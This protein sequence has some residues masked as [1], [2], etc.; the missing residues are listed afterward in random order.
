MLKKRQ[1][2]FFNLTFSQSFLFLG[3][4]SFFSFCSL[5]AQNQLFV[6]S[7]N[8]GMIGSYEVAVDGSITA[9]QFASEGTDA[10]GI[11]YDTANDVLYQLNRTDSRIDVYSNVSTNP[12]LVT[13]STSDFT[14]GREI[15]V[16]GNK[17]VVADDVAGAGNFVVY[18]ITPTSIS[19]DKIHN[20]SI[21]LWGIHTNGNQLIAIVDASS[22]VA[23]FENFF[24]QAGGA[25][26]ASATVT[27]DGLVRT[28]GLTY[29]AENDDMYLTDI[30]AASSAT[31]GA[32]IRV[33]NW[34]S[35]IIDGSVNPMEQIRVEGGASLLG[36]PVDIALDKAN[37]MVY[38]AERARDGGR[39]L[40]FKTPSATG[41]VAPTY[42]ELF[43]G[44]S[45]VFLSGVETSL[46]TCDFVSGGSVSFVNG[47][48]ETTIIVD[49]ED[50][51]LSFASTV[52]A[53]ASNYSFT[54]V[55][56]DGSAAG[57]I[58]GI[59]PS[60]T[61]EFNGAGLGLCKVYGLSYTGNLTITGGD[62]L[63]GGQDLSDDCFM[64]SSN[65][66]KVNRVAPQATANQFF[67]SSNT[68]G[69]I[70]AYE[71]LEDGSVLGN[72]FSSVDLDAD[73]IHYDAVNDVLYQLN[74]T[75][76]RVD[77][78]SNGSTNPTLIASS[79]SDFTNGREIAVTGSK[80]VVADD[81]AGGGNLVVYNITPTSITLDRIY[82]T[83]IEL[84]GIH[85]NGNQLIAVVDASDNV[86][87]Y[88]DFFNQQVGSISASATIAI[89]GLVRTHGLTYDSEN[90]DM[91][92]T[93]I[94]LASSAT[95]GALVRV[96][97]WTAASADG[98]VTASEQIRVKGIT[99]LLGN[100]V[101]IALD[102]DND[103][104]YVAERARDGGRILGFRAPT[105]TGGI[106]PTYKRLF[107]GASAVF[108]SGVEAELDEC[109]YVESGV[110]SFSTGG[111]EQTIVIDG[112]SDVLSFQS[113]VGPE[114]QGINF[115]YVVTNE[116]GMILGI[117]PSNLV[118]FD[119]AGLGAC[120]VY[121]LT[122]TGVLLI[123]AGDD[124][125]GG[126]DLSSDC[127]KLS[128]NNLTVIRTAS[129]VNAQLFASS[130]TTGKIGVFSFLDDGNALQDEFDSQDVDADGIYFD[131]ENDV[132]YQLNR[133]ASVVNVYSDVNASLQAGN[134][135]TLVATS[136]SDFTN[137]REIAVSGGKLIVADDVT[138]GGNLVIYD[139]T[140]TSIA[141]DKVLNTSIELWGIHANG[142]QLIAVVDASGD[143]AIFEDV[144]N[145]PAGA[146]DADATISIENLVRTHG[147]TYDAEEDY[148][149]LTD[150]GSASFAGDGALITIAN[151]TA[152]I[153]DGT[154][155]ADEQIRNSGG[156]S[157]LGNP[158]DVAYD[159]DAGMIYVAERAR[160]GGLILGFKKP[161]LSGG[162][163]PSY[164]VSFPG[165]S[166]VN[167]MNTLIIL[168][169]CGL[170]DGAT[171]SLS[172]GNSEATIVV[173][174]T[175]D[176]IDFAST[177]ELADGV[178]FT[179]VITDANGIVLGVPA[180]GPID[181]N[182]SGVGACNVYGLSYTGTLNVAMGDDLFGGQD[183]SDD[184]FDLSDNSATV[185]RIDP[186]PVDASLFISSNTQAK[187]GVYSI[188]ESG[189]I[190]SS[191]FSTPFNDA[192]GIY[193]DDA[194][195]VLYQLN[196][197]DNVIQ[198]YSTVSTNPTLIASSTSDFANGRE[199]AVN[200]NKL[201]VADDVTGANKFVI[202]DITPTSITL[203]KILDADIDL[204]GIHADGDRLIAV[205]DN[206]SEV[207][208]YDDFFANP[209]GPVSPTMTVTIAGMVRTHGLDYDAADDM[210]I[211]TDVGLASDTNDGALVVVRD[212][213]L[214]AFD[215]TVTA[216]EQARA[217]GGVDFLGNPVDV[218][219]D[220]QN[221]RIY[222]AERANGGGRI[223]GFLLPKL[224]GGIAPFYNRLY[225][226]ASAVF[227]PEGPCDFLTGG[228]ITFDDPGMTTTQNVTVNDGIAN[229]LFFNSDVDAAA[230]GYSQTYVVTD[231]NG[232]ILG[233][234]PSNSVDFD[235]SGVG[236]CAVF[237]VSYTGNLLV[238]AGDNLLTSEIS[239]ACSA[240]SDNF[241][242]VIR[243]E[244]FINDDADERSSEESIIVAKLFPSP[245]SSELNLV[246]DALTTQEGIVNIYN[247]AGA[248][249]LR[250]NVSLAQGQNTL[251][252]DVSNLDKG[253]YFVQIPGSNQ[254]AK[255]VKVNF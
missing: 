4:F 14:N 232:I 41:G 8:S 116:A 64:L 152:A 141:L 39:L 192:D 145:Q 237:N 99:S 97:N 84:W 184:C 123:S 213:M 120:N 90:D 166:A 76:N 170:V 139:I 21:E 202:Y 2:Q 23:I 156:T 240:I 246:I 151:W 247:A 207:A 191:S 103:M 121:G 165:A 175:P 143:V 211:L 43:G 65:D 86:A 223:L 218:A 57:T 153:A 104:V 44:A 25:I 63:F 87:V 138:G 251:T 148:M 167:L 118:D 45:A 162:I 15:A 85:A 180:A 102:K 124:L 130:N 107:A 98:T 134:M 53:S 254:V 226:G 127:F 187:V 119:G 50:D 111:T 30:G 189:T 83:S 255:F 6:S 214:A 233:I 203:D 243:T 245:V 164:M 24:N 150:I 215:G 108:L 176:M 60:N 137:G 253:M 147:L 209:A 78:Y 196:R 186:E 80:L 198:I 56:T 33:K 140:P 68:S 249:S 133:T 17:L 159:K 101:D 135:P 62:A 93:D 10:D 75:S 157:K 51:F 250:Q 110:L 88:D 163:A 92:L 115:T 82:N 49:T 241:L 179:Y 3:L 242:T 182:G 204:W 217:F 42:S 28:H 229:I 208:V 144:F 89:E 132:L 106:A 38:V 177:A 236:N 69:L 109:D 11:H 77:V 47:D 81:L 12:T 54:Y 1:S 200:G 168:E 73:G 19:L 20:T 29:D 234:P 32:L 248:L 61:V 238:A 201:V 66:L 230:G 220:K 34:T 59:P 199:I 219:L 197:A 22:D 5:N 58:L 228:A 221:E 235:G 225:P 95:D 252:F 205:V 55:V 126:Q 188:L 239:D 178:S 129:N 172:D 67:V 169:P 131:E 112:Q 183:L 31:D 155:S 149:V 216:S 27:I 210:L 125:F 128:S 26:I 161:T 206:S 16:T 212:F 96:M 35:A 40:A 117:P 100:P 181:F 18:D 158:V 48:T 222:V 36:N 71:I 154:V 79:T 72:E 113:T 46:N 70:G 114:P 193:Y 160:E 105:L 185:N 173:D 91:Y 224:S 244:G 122:Y 231:V 74:R 174:A 94:G 194:N 136:T 13:S 190:A 52:D 142:D 195:D 227:I 9:S 37:N 7:N 146:V 171:V